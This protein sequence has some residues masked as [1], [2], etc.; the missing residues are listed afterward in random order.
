VQPD[1]T[2]DAGPSLRLVDPIPPSTHATARARRRHPASK[3]RGDGNVL[4]ICGDVDGRIVF[5]RIARRWESLRLVVADGGRTG[6]HVVRKCRP[7]LVVL[8]SRQPD[9]DGADLVEHLRARVLPGETPVIVLAHDDD[10]RERARFVWAGAS[11][12]HCKPLNVAAL[13]RTVAT[14]LDLAGLRQG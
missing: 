13:D 3:V 14:L 9:V 11:A 4:Y 6:L 7:R 1:A 2:R 12:Y 8:D 10:P 5:T